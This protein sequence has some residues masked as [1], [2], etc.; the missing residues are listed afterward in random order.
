MKFLLDTSTFLWVI[1][2]SSRLSPDVR[3]ALTAHGARAYVSSASMWEISIKY[4]LGKL[5]LPDEPDLYLPKRRTDS[6]IDLLE[7][8]EAEV[9][10]VHRL[11]TIHRDPFDRLLIVQANCHGLVLATN[12]PII[13]RY[14]VRTFW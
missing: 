1:T 11:P 7:I 4:R 3:A 2:G 13:R 5:A 8:G 6:N 12:D 9:C 10:Q 14:P